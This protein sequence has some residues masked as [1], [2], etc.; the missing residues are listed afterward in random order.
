MSAVKTPFVC[1]ACR[2]TLRPACLNPKR[3]QPQWNRRLS[4]AGPRHQGQDH[5]FKDAVFHSGASDSSPETRRPDPR[6]TRAS[7]ELTQSTGRYSGIRLQPKE[8]LRLLDPDRGG[9]SIREG[10]QLGR[11]KAVEGQFP[12]NRRHEDT[13]VMRTL[14]QHVAAR[15]W[16]E[17]WRILITTHNRSVRGKLDG[18]R[19]DQKF[20]RNLASLPLAFIGDWLDHHG[21]TAETSDRA[22]G[23][24]GDV[25]D[26]SPSPVEIARTL[27]ASDLLSPTIQAAMLCY[28]LDSLA[29]ARVGGGRSLS[30]EIQSLVIEEAM[31]IW[32]DTLATHLRPQSLLPG[33]LISQHHNERTWDWSFLPAADAIVN[34]DKGPQT[35]F[36]DVLSMVV[37]SSTSISDTYDFGSALL[38]TKK[39]VQP[40]PHHAKDEDQPT[41]GGEVNPMYAP[42]L[43]FIDRVLEVAPPRQTPPF[44]RHRLEDVK[45]PMLSFY[46]NFA[47]TMQLQ[48]VP[49]RRS[50]PIANLHRSEDP[51]SGVAPNNANATTLDEPINQGLVDHAGRVDSSE[52]AD[53]MD[54]SPEKTVE[55]VSSR[56]LDNPASSTLFTPAEVGD[57]DPAVHKFATRT[58]TRIGRAVEKDNLAMAQRCYQD[59]LDYEQSNVG[60]AS[61]PLFLYE[62]L[63]DMFMSLRR[64]KLA[65]DVWN[66]IQ[67]GGLQPTVKTWTVMMRGTSRVGDPD[68]LEKLWANMRANN[69]QPD[70]HAWSARIFG[71]ISTGKVKR[72]L[73]A[74]EEMGNEWVDVKRSWAEM[75]NLPSTSKTRKQAEKFLSGLKGGRPAKPTIEVANAAIAALARGPDWHIP[76]VLKWAMQFG[77]EADLT[78]YNMLINVAMRKGNAEEAM[79]L[80]KRMQE[81]NVEMNSSTS[82]VI[83]AALFHSGWLEDLSS[84]EQADRILGL[85]GAIEAAD[86]RAGL[87]LKGYAIAVHGMLTK[88]SNQLAARELLK[89]MR[90]H[91]L[92]PSVHIYTMLQD[93]YLDTEHPDFA[94]AESLWN[95]I[96]SNDS[97]YGTPRNAVFYDRA[98][99]GYAQHHSALGIGRLV[100]IFDR[101]QSEGKRYS[102]RGL[103]AA[104]MAFAERR[105]WARLGKLVDDIRFSRGTVSSGV[106]RGYGQYDF[107]LFIISTGLLEKE[108]ITSPDQL[109]TADT[110]TKFE[111]D[112]S[113]E[114][115]VNA[116]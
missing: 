36:K 60:V 70:A 32:H 63:I 56:P 93:A 13:E 25:S 80:L 18:L 40:A 95:D 88:Y 27:K 112:M 44:L 51:T 71:L 19:N 28:V 101:M 43:S 72:A 52:A 15:R 113:L 24:T 20:M 31:C 78:T 53:T 74:L 65:A 35:T 55:L 66:V 41:D 2:S 39:I 87:D 104:A 99:K 81:R 103:H 100:E 89:H 11:Q 14:V 115:G 75:K 108:G 79:G 21:S 107:W 83:L 16:P 92:T 73:S 76:R 10:V 50:D 94:A 30:P 96:H 97:G 38:L 61:L 17:A 67:Q 7:G 90:D 84:Q 98:M 4:R 46:E 86:A 6:Q 57:L 110:T 62:H 5:P 42:L 37:P 33:V 1:A 22:G 9:A 91:G 34:T 116:M 59:V 12:R 47:R 54:M 58:I 49:S 109:M 68:S 48:D 26:V 8:L 114:V 106:T 29:E 85:I 3:S 111:K 45:G 82:T 105:N 23:S 64:P 102:W 69:V 77:L